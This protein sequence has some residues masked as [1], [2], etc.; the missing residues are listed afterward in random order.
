MTRRQY[1]TGSVYPRSSDGLWIGKVAVGFTPTGG[2]RYAHVSGKTEAEAKRKLNAKVKD[3]AVNGAPESGTSRATV[4]SY[5]TGW[6]DRRSHELRPKAYS[7]VSSAMS[8]HVIPTIGHRPLADLTPGDVRSVHDA[9]RKAGKSQSAMRGAHWALTAMLKDA[10]VE[11]HNVPS[12]VLLVKAPAKG[13]TDR[14]AIPTEH[15][16]TL[17]RHAAEMGGGSRW[18]A[19]LLNGM[20]Q[21][22]CLGLTWDAIDFDAEMIDVS[23]QLQELPYLDKAAGTFRVPDGYE[24]RHLYG[25]YHL[26]RP[27]TARGQRLVP[28]V[29]WLSASLRE[30]QEASPANPWGLVWADV[31]V[32]LGRDNPA[33]LRAS[34]DR[35]RWMDLQ[36][37]AG[38]PR[39][40]S[41]RRYALHEARHSTATLLLEA[42]VD[43]TVIIQILGQ[44]S[45]LVA[46][47]YQ[48]VRTPVMREALEAV[49]AKLQA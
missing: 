14:E 26:V 44:S 9:M 20:R 45:Q 47:G 34:K 35:A 33:V 46:R 25:R 40:P 19:A 5:S 24:R 28:M 3:L 16:V 36:D 10:T 21:G 31:D 42:G 7:A 4:R 18:V 22:E 17:L 2:R 41:G 11:G 23:W 13:I 12:R 15:A 29:P 43:P 38:I 27:K 49:A 30:W 39:H 1:G 6:L 48:T 37:A 32:R 8:A